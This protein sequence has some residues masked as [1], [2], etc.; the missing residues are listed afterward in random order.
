VRRDYAY[1]VRVAADRFPDH[2]A[3]AYRDDHWTY[4]ELDRATDRLA[5]A[6]ARR[7]MAGERVLLLLNN[8]PTTVLTY[9]ALARAGAVA[10]PVN[11]KL[12]AHEIA[13]VADDCG[14]AAIVA[15][16]AFAPGAAELARGCASVQRLLVVNAAE[17]GDADERIED[18]GA[19]PDEPIAPVDPDAV[20]LIVY[21]SGT[22][23]V[24]K[25]VARTH[26]ANLWACVNS[27]LG[28]TRFADDVEVFVLPLF[29]IAFIFQ[30]MPMLMAG[31]TVVL[32]GGFDPARTWELLERHR[33]TRV[34]LAP[35]MIDSMLA[36]DGHADR[37][38]STLR[39][40]NTAY[41]FPERVRTAATERFGEILAYMYG[42][43]EAQL[44]CST[45]AQFAQDP[46]NAGHPMGLMRIRVVD[47]EHRPL[48]TGAV[49]E[50]TLDAPSVMAGYHGRE[51]ATEEALVDGWLYT[52][53][54]GYLDE[55]G[56]VHVVGRKKSMIKTGGFSVD[57]V[58]VENALLAYPGVREAAVVGVADE[59]WGEQVV[60]F[61]SPADAL[62]GAEGEVLAFLKSRIA[63]YKCPKRLGLL[64]ELPKNATGKIERARLRA[65]A[66]Q[67][68]GAA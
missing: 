10:V 13:F 22:S 64:P 45:P 7:G 66:E 20:A 16:A 18:L 21:T 26:D 3:F 67:G 23:G 31:G 32:C 48:D 60:A 42:L 52:G 11:P 9:L 35:T 41:E 12:L 40:L 58:E 24:P 62:A 61:A 6:F 55:R 33:A 2:V 38:V 46:T 1:P 53:D 49:G 54:L 43:T 5:A 34:F 44:C 36:L 50:I 57:P 65:L 59:H 14:A 28:Q 37:D 15:D 8:H 29:G 4:R 68:E 19:E 17:A 51:D 56:R 47:D 63:A 25:G 27:M 39:V 30:V